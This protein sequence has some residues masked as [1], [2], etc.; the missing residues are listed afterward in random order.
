MA[1]VRTTVTVDET[2]LADA[3]EQA[4]R[5]QT[6]R[7][8]VLAVWVRLGHESVQA[9]ALGAAYD[10]AYAEPDPDGPPARVRRKRAARFDA[11]WQ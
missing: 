10:R 3:A 7:A 5:E 9:E 2:L 4:E 6:S 11:T 1:S 8:H